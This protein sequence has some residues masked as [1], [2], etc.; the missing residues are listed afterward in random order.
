[1]RRCSVLDPH[2]TIA[3]VDRGGDGTN[4]ECN[5]DDLSDGMVLQ[6]KGRAEE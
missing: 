4:E 3:A 6:A 2:Y 5:G 1:M